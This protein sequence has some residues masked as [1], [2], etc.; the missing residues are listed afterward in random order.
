MNFTL[1]SFHLTAGSYR[2]PMAAIRSL[3][4]SAGSAPWAPGAGARQRRPH[5]GCSPG[6]SSPGSAGPKPDPFL[7]NIA[8]K[9]TGPGETG[10]PVPGT[11]AADSYLKPKTR[12]ESQL[13]AWEGALN[14]CPSALPYL[15]FDPCPGEP[16]SPTLITRNKELKRGCVRVMF[17]MELCSSPDEDMLTSEPPGPQN[18]P[19]TAD[20]S[21]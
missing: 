6:G 19:F 21:G 4:S 20:V 7:E 5:H 14:W 2:D 12:D 17:G 15:T 18:A 13:I 1:K 8:K 16:C 3:C 9:S 10:H 11:P